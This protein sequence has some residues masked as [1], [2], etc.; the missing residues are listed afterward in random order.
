IDRGINFVGAGGNANPATAPGNGF[1]LDLFASGI[2]FSE[3]RGQADPNLLAIAGANLDGGDA[4]PSSGF[5]GG[6]GGTLNVGT[7]ARPITGDVDV[8]APITAATGRNGNAVDCGGAGG[9]VNVVANGTVTASSSIN[10]SD[11]TQRRESRRGGN[12]RIT[13]RRTTGTAIR[14]TSTA[15]IASLL[16][17]GAPGPGG[18]V[19]F[20]SGG[21]DV[22]VSGTVTADRG[23]I[24]VENTG[25]N[26]RV[27]LNGATLSADVVRARAFGDNG[28]LVVN[29]GTI[30]ADSMIKLY[31]DG[32]NGTVL[33]SGNVRLS[34]DSTKIITGN[35][36]TI[37]P[38]VVVTIGGRQSAQVYTNNPN[39]TGFGGNGSSSGTF[40]G[41]GATTQSRAAAPG[42]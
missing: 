41:A 37:S 42:Y 4:A 30:S 15:Q 5:E 39:Y 38:N 7:D 32:S 13:S 36:V 3:R 9:S 40:G 10:V 8:D 19:I 35:T 17:A 6:S 14:L 25:A 18:E 1:S 21:G 24:D 12:V 22:D 34:G 31:A 20:R 26:G 2:I 11:K 33:F 28:T 27:A 29:G 16:A 23:R